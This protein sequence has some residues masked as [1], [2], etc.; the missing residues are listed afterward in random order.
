MTDATG[1]PLT[2]FPPD[3]LDSLALCDA[4]GHQGAGDRSLVS[5]DV[6]VQEVLRAAAVL[7]LRFGR[8]QDVECVYRSGVSVNGCHVASFHPLSKG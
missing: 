2:D 4:C 5:L 6:R 8:L 1:N 7:G 3:R